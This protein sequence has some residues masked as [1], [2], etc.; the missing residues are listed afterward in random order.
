M[1]ASELRL[2]CTETFARNY[3]DRLLEEAD[4][5]QFITLDESGAIPQADLDRANIAFMSRDVWPKLN[6]AFKSS[7][8]QAPN[9]RWFHVMSAGTDG[10]I[11]PHLLEREVR[12]TRSSGA[13]ANAMAETVFMFLHGLTRDLRGSGARQDARHWER[14]KWN[15]LEGKTIAVLGYGPIGQRVVDLANAYDMRPVILRRTVRG[16][17]PCE[18]RRLD[19]LVDVVAEADILVAALP[20]NDDTRGIVSAQVIENMKPGA[21]FVNI[22]RGR[23]VDQEAL[24]AAL[25]D[26][27][28]SG[29][30]LDA[31]EVEPLPADDPLWDLENVLITSHDSGGSFGSPEKVVD[32]F[33]ENLGLY[34]SGSELRNEVTWENVNQPSS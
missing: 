4:G 22:A 26:G 19:E 21:K 8:R 14:T 23:L 10:P 34:R 30:G 13:S 17:E 32:L 9:L 25:S 18:T 28:L 15:E 11:F 3:A 27:R 31:F 12:I 16:D 7:L 20:L 24:T 6:E 1:D 5:M 33:F 29:A 2:L